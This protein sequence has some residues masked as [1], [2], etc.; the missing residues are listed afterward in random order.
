MYEH[1]SEAA[2]AD[3]VVFYLHS[4]GV[5]HIW[6]KFKWTQDWTRY[7]EAFLFEKPELCLHA[8][9]HG[10]A[11]CGVELYQVPF[12]HYAGNFWWTT[13]R[14][15]RRL[16]EPDTMLPMTDSTWGMPENWIGSVGDDEMMSLFTGRRPCPLPLYP[17]ERA[18]RSWVLLRLVACPRGGS[19]CVEPCLRHGGFLCAHGTRQ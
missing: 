1:C 7:M 16:Q 13:C 5:G 6:P 3:H 18:C 10:S 2:H 17:P 19:S 14:R 4:K 12:L 11:A 15:V 8:L 9:E